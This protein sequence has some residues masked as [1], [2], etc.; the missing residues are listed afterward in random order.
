MR[1]MVQQPWT[2]WKDDIFSAEKIAPMAWVP[3]GQLHRYGMLT[4]YVLTWVKTQYFFQ[5]FP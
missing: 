5:L 2:I 1:V 3:W 4:F